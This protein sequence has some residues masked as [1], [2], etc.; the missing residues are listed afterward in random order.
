MQ[1]IAKTHAVVAIPKKFGIFL[2]IPEIFPQSRKDER[3][4]LAQPKVRWG[5]GWLGLEL[6]IKYPILVPFLTTDDVLSCLPRAP[7]TS[8]SQ[9]KMSN[10]CYTS[11]SLANINSLLFIFIAVLP[12]YID[13][14]SL[15]RKN[16][17]MH[18]FA[19]WWIIAFELKFE[20][21]AIVNEQRLLWNM[22][23]K[24]QSAG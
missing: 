11:A 24:Y 7:S 9:N 23:F 2:F 13:A 10:N 14:E 20:S 22:L 15:E 4:V 3:G 1:K 18:L 19:T 17:I 12:G 8:Y 5:K 21:F 16:L 6:K